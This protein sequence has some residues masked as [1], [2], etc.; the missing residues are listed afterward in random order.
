MDNSKRFILKHWINALL[1]LFVGIVAWFSIRYAKE[2][3]T[4]A[5][6]TNDIRAIWQL[7]ITA[8]AGSVGIG[9][10]I[11][12][13]RSASTAAES[14]RVTKDKEKREQSS[15]LIPLSNIEFFSLNAPFYIKQFNYMLNNFKKSVRD[16]V[17]S[18]VTESGS[19]GIAE[20][21]IERD[22]YLKTIRENACSS[23][24]D[25]L[26]INLIN[27]GK[28]SCVNLEYSFEFLNL[29]KFK[30]YSFQP[31]LRLLP[32]DIH[33]IYK[34]IVY[35]IEI[36][37]D[38]ELMFK[39]LYLERFVYEE[40]PE[41]VEIGGTEFNYEMKEQH[42]VEYINILKPSEEV[43]IIIPNEFLMLCKHYMNMSYI[44]SEV[45][46]NGYLREVDNGYLDPWE[47]KNHIKPIGLLNISFFEESLIRI[48]EIDPDMRTELIYEVSLKDIEVKTQHESI[49]YYLEVNL[50]KPET[51]KK[52]SYK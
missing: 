23:L 44:Y 51:L 15:H 12:S 6:T 45:D 48:G 8:I 25:N 9:T 20:F 17:N 30:N 11:N 35:S 28:G 36:N 39:D 3:S 2:Y 31:D 46:K 13:A 7:A 19:N 38:F 21:D 37:D 33:N 41:W 52:R 29:D 18:S 26:V 34:P 22:E 49:R 50:N 27:V 1:F 14:M 16:A 10:I 24:N 47:E 5:K 4:S 32:A 42:G 40:Y 43:Q